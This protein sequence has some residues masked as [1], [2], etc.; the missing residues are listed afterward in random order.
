MRSLERAIDEQLAQQVGRDDEVEAPVDRRQR[1]RE[2]GRHDAGRGDPVH[3]DD[4]EAGA[5]ARPQRL[6][7]RPRPG[8]Q[9]ERPVGRHRTAGE[10]LGQDL[11]PARPRVRGAMSRAYSCRSS[12]S[13]RYGVPTSARS[14]DQ[15]LV[16]RR[17][18]RARPALA[19]PS[20]HAR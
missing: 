8:A 17:A 3:A 2:I 6:A 19:A 4:V 13:A 9:I 11:A 7:D 15:P 12:G 10:H 14:P 1:D 18:A 16:N 5:E 20:R